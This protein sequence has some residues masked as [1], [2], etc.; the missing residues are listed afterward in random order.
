MDIHYSVWRGK[1]KDGVRGELGFFLLSYIILLFYKVAQLRPITMHVNC[2]RSRRAELFHS[3]DRLKWD[4]HLSLDFITQLLLS[5]NIFETASF[6][7]QL[8][9]LGL[10]FKILVS[11]TLAERQAAN[12]QSSCTCCQPEGLG[13]NG[14]K[15]QATL[16]FRRAALRLPAKQTITRYTSK[17]FYSS[18]FLELTPILN[19]YIAS[20]EPGVTDRTQVQLRSGQL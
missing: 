18:L 14:N 8:W 6:V 13:L 4:W 17:W 2:F 5:E 16:Q 19:G 3:A 9:I 7:M 1:G 11:S 20:P 15:H 10:L 12:S